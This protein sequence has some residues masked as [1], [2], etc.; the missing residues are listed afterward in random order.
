M[1]NL[2]FI[3]FLWSSLILSLIMLIIIG[4]K[5]LFQNHISVKWQ[6]YI[7][8]IFLIMLM[9]PFIPQEF[10]NFGSI[11]GWNMSHRDLNNQVV[12]N[13]NLLNAGN[14]NVFQ[15]EVGLQDFTLSM[16]P[17]T[18]TYLNVIGISLWGMGMVVCVGVM[19]FA[20]LSMRKIKNSTKPI[21]NKE[22][23]A[24]FQECKRELN[25]NRS[26]VLGQSSHVNVPIVFGLLKTYIIL[27]EEVINKLSLEDMRYIIL[28]EL[29]HYKKKDIWINYAMCFYKV[30]YWFNPCVHW[31]FNI[32]KTDREI[33]CDTEVLNL[34]D[35]SNYIDYGRTIINFIEIL[36]ESRSLA[37]VTSM[38]GSKK[39]VMKRIKHIASFKKEN[40]FLQVKSLLIFGLIT[41]IALSQV[42]MV[43]VMAYENNKYQFES[44]KVIEEDLS[45]YFDGVEGSFVLYDL[46]ND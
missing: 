2:F 13:I 4:A 7:W 39:Q 19:T 40:K 32:M 33:A 23:E 36:S 22:I 26:L 5:R 16:K 21:K 31:A 18:L 43:A 27:P 45:S 41:T 25:I 29:N 9:I 35:E 46:Q 30:V 1:D 34:L 6:Y 20:Y 42:P 15:G 37:M 17:S 14:Q 3:R 12:N 24:L 28:H 10:L 8:M 11:I 44:D 38:G